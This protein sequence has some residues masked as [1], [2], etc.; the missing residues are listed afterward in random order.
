MSFE[1][2]I[3]A[4]CCNWCS[5]AAAD[6]AGV[7]RMKYPPN[8]RI[9][10]VPCSGKVDQTY[11][12]KALEMGADG[13]MVTGCMEGQ[14]HYLTGNFYTRDRVERLKRDLEKIGLGGRVDMFM[15]SA[16]MGREFAETATRFTEKIRELGPNP[17]K[18][19][20]QEG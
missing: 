1:P 2:S 15:M 14:C 3:V 18:Q 6:L 16:A 10:H 5:Y 4:F 9:I 19:V 7:S 17:Y 12:L 8:V 11:I 13:V 20:K